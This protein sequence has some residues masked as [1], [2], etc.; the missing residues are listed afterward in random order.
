M[1]LCAG[2]LVLTSPSPWPC[3]PVPYA[4]PGFQEAD[5]GAA[6][7]RFEMAVEARTHFLFPSEPDWVADARP[8][9]RSPDLDVP[10][11]AASPASGAAFPP[12]WAPCPA[13]LSLQR[14]VFPVLKL[15]AQPAPS[16]T[17]RSPSRGVVRASSGKRDW[18]RW[19]LRVRGVSRA[20]EGAGGCRLEEGF[21]PGLRAVWTLNSRGE[22][23]VISSLLK[24]ES[25][26]T[27]SG[28]SRA[29]AGGGWREVLIPPALGWS[30]SLSPPCGGPTLWP[31]GL[32]LPPWLL[33]FS[34][35]LR[36]AILHS[37][38]ASVLLRGLPACPVL[39]GVSKEMTAPRPHEKKVF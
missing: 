11:P 39:T 24:L 35:S 15:L 17:F 7:T 31:G 3:W 26:D 2:A 9:A 1:Q 28:L 19:Q 4:F 14:P 12:V 22:E 27:C 23:E 8:V 13:G 6:E 10:A 33:S 32:G 25:E 20:S 30:R 16:L 18:G 36:A 29:A 37:L 38:A 21:L 5:T 34:H